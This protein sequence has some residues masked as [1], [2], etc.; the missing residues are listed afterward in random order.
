MLRF[1]VKDTLISFGLALSCLQPFEWIRCQAEQK[2][3][4][5]V[6]AETNQ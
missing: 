6:N 3:Y 4:E 2:N 5:I 1:E